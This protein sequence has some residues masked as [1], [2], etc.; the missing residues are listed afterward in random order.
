MK[1]EGLHVEEILEVFIAL[2]FIAKRKFILTLFLVVTLF[3]INHSIYAEKSEQKHPT[4]SF[5]AQNDYY[6]HIGDNKRNYDKNYETRSLSLDYRV[7]ERRATN[8]M[9]NLS[10]A[11]LGLPLPP[12]SADNTITLEKIKLG[13]KL[14][15]DRRLSLN[16]TVS[17][18]MC[19]IPEHGFTNHEIKTSVGIEGRIVRRNAPTIYNVAYFHHFFHD[20]REDSLVFQ[21][22]TPLL[23]E[24]EMGNIAF[25]V[26]INKIKNLSDYDGLFEKA[27]GEGV[28]VVNIGQALES[29]QKTLVSANSNFDKW[30]YGKDKNALSDEAKHGFE[31][32]IGKAGCVSCHHINSEHALFMDNKLHNTGVGYIASM[33]KEPDYVKVQIAPDVYVDVENKLIDAISGSIENDIGLYEISKKPADRWKY[34][35]PSLRN[36]TLTPPYMH[37]GSL[38]SLEEVIEFYNQGGVPHSLLSPLVRPLHLGEKEKQ[39]LITF[40]ENLTGDNIDSLVRDAFTAPVGEVM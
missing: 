11:Q 36:I 18:A 27:F 21:V 19:H 37:N 38:S 39:A 40:L 32:F 33:K 5:F 7:R 14:F 17:C 25:A 9:E 26:V 12:V 6:R 13:K 8:L 23:A 15:F 10:K 28:S 1:C 22:W 24:N 3:L 4:A 34:K 29:Y 20:S 35:T 30:Y 16:N 2:F 31:L